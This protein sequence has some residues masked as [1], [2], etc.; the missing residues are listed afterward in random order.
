[1]PLVS[2]HDCTQTQLRDVMRCDDPD[3]CHRARI[4]DGGWGEVD[5]FKRSANPGL[6]T[7]ADRIN[8]SRTDDTSLHIPAGRW[9]WK[10]A[11]NSLWIAH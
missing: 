1:M 10:R 3:A 5:G 8:L 11:S 4:W 6:D 2:V 7:L 9:H